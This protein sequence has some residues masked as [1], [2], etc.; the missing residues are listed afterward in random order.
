EP[1]GDSILLAPLQ[2]SQTTT[3]KIFVPE[4]C[5]SEYVVVTDIQPDPTFPLS[6]ASWDDHSVFNDSFSQLLPPPTPTTCD[7]DK[8]GQVDR[9]DLNAILAAGNTAAVSDD[10]RDADGNGVVTVED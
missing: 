8:N 5:T 1:F 9:N 6:I 7:V 2:A 4:K 10:P 3:Q